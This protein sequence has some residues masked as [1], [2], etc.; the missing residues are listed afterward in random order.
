MLHTQVRRLEKEDSELLEMRRKA[1]ESLMKKT[2]KTTTS[3]RVEVVD[4][5]RKIII[6]LNEASTSED[7]TS[8]EEE[9]EES[10][11]ASRSEVKIFCC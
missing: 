8:E 6:P 7:E 5:D 9:E 11:A 4:R 2:V 1:L 10:E 3:T